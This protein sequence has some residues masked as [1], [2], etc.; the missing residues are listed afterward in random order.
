MLPFAEEIL[1]RNITGMTWIATESWIDSF[2]LKDPPFRN[3]FQG[4]MGFALRQG[5]IPGF[6]EFLINL[7]PE[8]KRTVFC[9][10]HKGVS[11]FQEMTAKHGLSIR[12][13]NTIANSQILGANKSAFNAQPQTTIKLS[14]SMNNLSK[15]DAKDEERSMKDGSLDEFLLELWEVTFNCTWKIAPVLIQPCTG[16]ESLLD[17]YTVFTDASELRVTYNIYMAVYSITHALHDLGK[18]V[19]GFGPFGNG[20]CA[21]MSE[22]SHRQVL[23][24]CIEKA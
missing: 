22:F 7:K 5:K 16:H 2:Y 23:F 4:T 15:G 6:H 18:C 13:P 24:L 3:I 14:C 17:A 19:P 8:I 10:K 12:F 9:E 20:L 11:V 21:N 1:Q